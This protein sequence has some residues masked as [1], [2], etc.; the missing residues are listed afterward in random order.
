MLCYAFHR[1]YM[2]RVRSAAERLQFLPSCI[3][4]DFDRF[5]P[6]PA[7]IPLLLIMR[8]RCHLSTASQHSP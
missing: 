6:H 8:A 2:T 3:A 1:S 7:F 5:N 4:G